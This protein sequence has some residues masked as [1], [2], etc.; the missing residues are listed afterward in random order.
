MWSLLAATQSGEPQ[1]LVSPGVLATGLQAWINS[2]GDIQRLYVTGRVATS[3]VDALSSLIEHRGAVGSLPAMELKPASALVVPA[4]FTFSGSGFG[5]GVGMSQWGAY[6]MAKEGFS[7]A[8]ILQHYFS[9]S[10]V[11]PVSDSMDVN[12]SLDSR[13]QSESFRLEQL[14]D[15]ASTLEMTAANGVVTLLKVND[16][17]TTTYV[18]GNIKVSVAGSTAVPTFTT[19]SLVFKWPGNRD[20]GTATGGPAVLRVAGPGLSIASGSRYRYGYVSVT[21]AKLSGALSLGLQVNNVLRLHDEY[22]YGIAEVSSSWPAA[23]LQTEVIA[24]RSYAYRKVKAGIRS[25]CACHVY[26]DPRDQN[27]T[28]YAKLAESGVGAKWKAAVD[29]TLTGTSQGQALTVGGQVVSAYYSAATGG[30]TQNNEDVWGGTPLSYT[31]SVDDHWSLQYASS[32]VARWVP[33]TFTQQQVAAAFGAPDVAY[34]DLSNRYPSGA[35]DNIIATSSN[36]Q[37]FVLGAETFKSRLNSGLSDALVLTKG[38]P[39]VWIW[40]VDTEIPTTSAAD[41]AM[42][43]SAGST[44]IAV[45]LPATASTTVVITQLSTDTTTAQP[46][47]ALAAAFAGAHRYG[48]LVNAGASLDATVKAE[49]TRRKASNVVLVGVVPSGL[50]A[51]L[52]AMKVSVQ[53]VLAGDAAALS[54][55]LAGPVVAGTPI[56]AASMRDTASMPIA[57]SLA[58]RTHAT[59]LMWDGASVPVQMSAY[60]LNGQPSAFTIVGSAETIPDATVAGLGAVTRLT[61]GNL[62]LA[63]IIGASQA[64][65]TATAAVVVASAAAPTSSLLVAAGTGLPMYLVDLTAPVATVSPQL[66]LRRFLPRLRLRSSRFPRAPLRAPLRFWRR[67][68]C[69]GRRLHSY[70]DFPPSRSSSEWA[71]TRW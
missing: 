53:S 42:Q 24:A 31:R 44:S 5:H 28:G 19:S 68:H 1:L 46:V 69:R 14:A 17:V 54:L 57:V 9:G 35:V 4:S 70:P 55:A 43:C 25:A 3:Q 48:L 32:T 29:G 6:G 30:A 36:G 37:Q 33:R 51:A 41:A 22:L 39:S 66:R 34:L 8:D 10:V 18:S 60:I 40:R 45:R 21:P 13:V 7:A 49:L 27:F 64:F 65:D 59:L 62:A 12:V 26:D 67:G 63:S 15:P 38:I 61:T 47:L 50:S 20:S 52:V 16:V 71:S 58:V 56:V 23:A 11:A 2:R